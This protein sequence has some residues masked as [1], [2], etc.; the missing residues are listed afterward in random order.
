MFFFIKGY[1]TTAWGKK[2]LNFGGKNITHINYGNIT[3]EI[4]FI[5][6]LNY[7]QKSL[8]E[9]AVTLSEDEK[10]SVKHL[11]K[12]FFNQNSYFSES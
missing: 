4:K 6:T 9:L 5:D 12:H 2:N 8:G 11:T 1:R 7:Y 3:G 10:K